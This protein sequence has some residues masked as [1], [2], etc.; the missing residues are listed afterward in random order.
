M[1]E[2]ERFLAWLTQDKGLGINTAQRTIGV[3]KTA[4][5][6]AWKRGLLES[7]PYIALPK[8]QASP[9]RG[10]PLEIDEIRK[11]LATAKSQHIQDFILLMIAT[12]ARPDAVLDLTFD[13]CDMERRL[14]TLNPEG[15]EQTKKHRPVVRMPEGILGLI[16]D[17]RSTATCPYI[18]SY[19]NTQVTSVKRAWRLLRDAA[20]LDDQVQPYSLRHTMARWLRAKSVPAWEVAAQLGHKQKNMSTTEIYAPFDPAYLEHSTRAIDELLGLVMN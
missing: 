1:L 12:A 13:R 11:L 8:K 17:R 10:R 4:L 9:P 19:K 14:I 7:V 15:R 2:Q 18:V 5:T 3:G 6:W 16:E 20:D